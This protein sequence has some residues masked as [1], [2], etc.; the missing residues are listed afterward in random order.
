MSGQQASE[1]QHLNQRS[2]G[3][4]HGFLRVWRNVRTEEDRAAR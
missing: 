1:N 3:D 4:V 2:N